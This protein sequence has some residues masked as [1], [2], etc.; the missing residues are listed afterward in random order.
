MIVVA[1]L[2]NATAYSGKAAFD[3][4]KPGYLARIK[5]ISGQIGSQFATRF[6]RE[7][8]INYASSATDTLTNARALLVR[9]QTSPEARALTAST[10]EVEKAKTTAMRDFDKWWERRPKLSQ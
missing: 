7:E 5:E 1:N 3:T 9:D 2:T 4:A 6:N 8:R 10:A